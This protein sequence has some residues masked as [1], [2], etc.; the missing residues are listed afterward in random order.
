MS[1][2]SKFIASVYFQDFPEDVGTL[3][4]EIHRNSKQ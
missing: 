3:I 1:N 2:I 4:L